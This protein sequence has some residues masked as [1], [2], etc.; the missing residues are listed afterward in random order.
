MSE[1][2]I[3]IRCIRCGHKRQKRLA[4]LG[5]AERVVYRGDRVRRE[6]YRLRCSQCGTPN[7]VTVE[8]EEED[9]DG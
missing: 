7:V 4:D 6:V 5:K 8:I 9:H 3:E 2:L 1:E